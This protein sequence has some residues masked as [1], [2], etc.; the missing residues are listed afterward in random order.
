M[1]AHPPPTRRTISGDF[2]HTHNQRFSLPGR[3]FVT[4]KSNFRRLIGLLEPA[5]TAIWNDR[6]LLYSL[7]FSVLEMLQ[8]GARKSALEGRNENLLPSDQP[9]TATENHLNK[10]HQLSLS[11]RGRM[12]V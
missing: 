6:N 10:A 1:R 9:V 3:R 5:D 8:G 2:L 4:T 7:S 12:R 11:L